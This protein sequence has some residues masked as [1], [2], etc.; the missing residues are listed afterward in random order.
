MSGASKASISTRFPSGACSE[1]DFREEFLSTTPSQPTRPGA[2]RLS[3]GV[4][5]KRHSMKLILSIRLTFGSVARQGGRDW[6]GTY[7]RPMRRLERL[8]SHV[9]KEVDPCPH[10]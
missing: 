10:R 1:A 7:R 3:V 4:R 8:R 5:Q 2:A 9:R 6:K